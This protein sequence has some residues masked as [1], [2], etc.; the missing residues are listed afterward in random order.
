[1]SL[2]LVEEADLSI[3]PTGSFPDGKLACVFGGS[4]VVVMGM[5][6]DPVLGSDATRAS[7]VLDLAL[8]VLELDNLERGRSSLATKSI[9]I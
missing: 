6:G 4:T 9:T 1:M 5:R 7:L 2:G 3:L 8:E